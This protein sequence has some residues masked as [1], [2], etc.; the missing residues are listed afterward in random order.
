VGGGGGRLGQVDGT[1]HRAAV[2]RKGEV[3]RRGGW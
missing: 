2:C 1:G 3:E